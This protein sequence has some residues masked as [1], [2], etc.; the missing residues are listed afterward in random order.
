MGTVPAVRRSDL[1]SAV[2]FRSQGSSAR[3]RHT[4]QAVIQGGFPHSARIGSEEDARRFAEE[5]RGPPRRV[6]VRYATP[7][8]SAPASE[9]PVGSLK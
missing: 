3:P 1:S 2:E 6:G 8:C 4:A 5:L 7:L 9:A